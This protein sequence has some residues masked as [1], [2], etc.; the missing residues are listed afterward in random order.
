MSAQILTTVP[1]LLTA[2]TGPI[3]KVEQQIL[4]NQE[5]IEI[6]LREQFNETPAPFYGSVDLRNAGFKLSPVDTNLFPAG[7]NNL[8][9]ASKP[10]CIQAIQITLLRYCPDA[11]NLVII[12]E[13]HT[14][15]LFYLESVATL[16]EYITLAGYHCYLGSLNPDLEKPNTIELPSGRSV[17]LSPIKRVNDEL[18]VEGVSPCAVLL[19]NDLSGGR[20]AIL[21]KL[22][23]TVVPPMD[24]G[25]SNRYKSDHFHMY[26][27][28]AESFA[29][30]IDIDPWL[31]NPLFRNCGAIDFMKREGED[32]LADNT[33]KLLAAIQ[34]KYDEYGITDKPY[35][36]MKADQGTYGMGVLIVN[37]AEEIRS[38]NRKQ[39]TKMS[40][41]K[42]GG[43]TSEVILQEGV[44]TLETVG[45]EKL[46]A[47]PVVYMIDHYV[48]G[49]FYRMHSKK[50]A[51][52]IL[53]SPGMSFQPLAFADPCNSPN[54]DD[55]C[56]SAPNRFY[57]YGIIG[58]LA[59][60][61]AAR[62]IA[63]STK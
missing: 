21:E 27:D 22:K 15:N 48:V 50:S 12:P 7:F 5:N 34:K 6:W 8:N 28:V 51:T 16:I 56:H 32:C 36:V 42:E 40:S 26:N 53:N 4:A 2:N 29:K 33:E 3:D 24:L 1:H 61:A 20:P 9:L 39:R 19:N 46:T 13:R 23:Q 49:G 44:P 55:D 57:A 18:Q 62:E 10:L 37:S 35:I 30:L 59:L 43:D 54:L 47:E 63:E 60:L 11:K 45:D 58:R 25:W 17:T 31:I 41:T 38:L 14:R 52:G